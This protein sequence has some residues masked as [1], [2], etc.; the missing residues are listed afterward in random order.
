[1]RAK[2]SG[3]S[4][5]TK[6]YNDMSSDPLCV[7]KRARGR[8]AQGEGVDT[9]SRQF[10]PVMEVDSFLSNLTVGSNIDPMNA[11]VAD[12]S[13]ELM[14]DFTLLNSGSTRCG[15]TATGI[16]APQSNLP[17]SSV[18]MQPV[19]LPSPSSED[20]HK[21]DFITKLLAFQT[22]DGS[23][24]IPDTEGDKLFGP[25]FLE[26]VKIFSH[27]VEELCGLWG[28]TSG[29]A[30]IALT[31]SIV[32]L[33]ENQYLSQ[34]VLWELLVQKAKYFISMY[35]AHV[36]LVLKAAENH[37]VGMKVDVDTRKA[38]LQSL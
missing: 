31:A 36:E 12:H 4:N 1:M 35:A 8:G 11:N 22:Y 2:S 33:L 30:Q 26:A 24:V 9:T 37:I 5:A 38:F 3:S 20:K 28:D 15:A 25:S 13:E 34:K 21:H 6:I 7:P 14:F 19:S 32:A 23:F 16:T 29:A 18:M 10:I 27:K 17:A